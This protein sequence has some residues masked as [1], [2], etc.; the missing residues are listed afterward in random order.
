MLN[1]IFEC[2]S[3]GLHSLQY[4]SKRPNKTHKKPF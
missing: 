2:Q 1:N 4:S 3:I